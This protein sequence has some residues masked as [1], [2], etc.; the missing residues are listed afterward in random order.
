M[1][2]IEYLNLVC[3]IVDNSYLAKSARLYV[4]TGANDNN[5]NNKAANTV[6]IVLNAH[7]CRA[8]SQKGEANETNT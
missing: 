2:F 3:S 7:K 8:K 6:K 5:N 1:F 4:L